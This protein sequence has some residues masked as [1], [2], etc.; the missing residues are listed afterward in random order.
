VFDGEIEETFA[1]LKMLAKYFKVPFKQDSV[2]KTL[3]SL[4]KQRVKVSINEVAQLLSSLGLQISKTKI[5]TRDATRLK[6]PTIIQWGKS[7][8]IVSQSNKDGITLISPKEGKIQIKKELISLRFENYIECLIPEK[9]RITPHEIFGFQ[10][11][12]P[13]L[14][15]YRVILGQVLFSSFIVQLFTLA[16]PLIIQVIIDK[17]ISQRSLDTLQVLILAKNPS[18]KVNTNNA[19]PRT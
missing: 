8:S 4:K 16:N 12:L 2:L 11:F 18:T 19:I 6:I 3:S 14:K 15:K 9:V 10:W 5:L 1:C 17:V 13:E 7:F